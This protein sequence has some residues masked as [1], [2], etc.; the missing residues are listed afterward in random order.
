MRDYD[1]IF[2]LYFDS[3]TDSLPKDS[4]ETLVAKAATLGKLTQTTIIALTQ[5]GSSSTYNLSRYKSKAQGKVGVYVVGHGTSTSESVG[6]CTAKDLATTLDTIS[7]YKLARVTFVACHSG[8]DGNAQA[9]HRFVGDFWTHAQHFVEEAVGY[10]G[11]VHMMRTRYPTTGA[12]PS[13]AVRFQSFSGVEWWV[14][15]GSIH[16]GVSHENDEGNPARRKI[17]YSNRGMFSRGWAA[18]VD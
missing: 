1:H 3:A 9:P 18:K 11:S 15:N 6:K 8:G 13:N 10:T 5:P 14:E 7:N 4:A 16:K 12:L 2:I 17:Y